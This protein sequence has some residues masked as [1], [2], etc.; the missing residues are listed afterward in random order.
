MTTAYSDK[1]VDSYRDSIQYYK[2]YA[3]ILFLTF[4]RKKHWVK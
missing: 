3:Y 4:S 1:F 2:H